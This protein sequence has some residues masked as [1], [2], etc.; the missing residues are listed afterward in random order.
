MVALRR[1]QWPA[2]AGQQA[3]LLSPGFGTPQPPRPVDRRDEKD[4][5]EIKPPALPEDAGAQLGAAADYIEAKDRVFAPKVLQKQLSLKE[6]RPLPPRGKGAGAWRSARAEALRMIA[7]L[8][9]EGRDF[10]QLT[11]GPTAEALLKAAL[12]DDRQLAAR[13]PGLVPSRVD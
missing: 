3:L 8:P 2:L 1:V 5:K 6:D 7:N 10:Y 13:G 12:S 9:P 4:G 11:Y